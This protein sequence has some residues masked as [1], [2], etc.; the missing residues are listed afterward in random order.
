MWAIAGGYNEVAKFLLNSGAVKPSDYAVLIYP[1]TLEVREN[2]QRKNSGSGCEFMILPQ[3]RHE[4]KV[5]YYEYKSNSR[6][7]QELNSFNES[8][9]MV[10]DLFKGDIRLIKYSIEKDKWHVWVENFK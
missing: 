5:T 2:N 6:Y 9:K 4:L 10:I 8:V 3:G 7:S 1:S